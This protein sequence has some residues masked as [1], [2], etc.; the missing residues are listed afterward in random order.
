LRYFFS[1]YFVLGAGGS[2]GDVYSKGQTESRSFFQLGGGDGFVN[3]GRI[4]F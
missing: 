2:L 1:E 3:T 4:E